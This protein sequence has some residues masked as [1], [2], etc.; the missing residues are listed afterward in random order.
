MVGALA[1]FVAFAAIGS[2]QAKADPREKLETAIPEA[3][4]LLESK[5]YEK[6]LRT[7]VTPEEFA[8]ITKQVSLEEFVKRFSEGKAPELLRVLKAVSGTKPS[9]DPSGT[10]ATFKHQL[11]GTAR[12]SIRFV[13]VEKFWYIQN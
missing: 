8:K 1:G 3:I 7:F 6:F 10:V 12:D 4:R 2:A 9:L 13:K 11:K 5:E